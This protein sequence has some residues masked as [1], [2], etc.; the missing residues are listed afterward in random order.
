VIYELPS[1]AVHTT[2]SGTTY[3]V[4]NGVWYLPSSG[5]NGVVYTVVPA[6]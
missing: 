4:A 2:I 5:A 6:P 1:G 3:Y